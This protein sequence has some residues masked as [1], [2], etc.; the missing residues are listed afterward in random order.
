[1]EIE[2][3]KKLF[4]GYAELFDIHQ[5][6][7]GEYVF[8]VPK[9]RIDRKDFSVIGKLVKQEQGE[10]VKFDYATKEGGYFRFKKGEAMSTATSDKKAVLIK[11]IF[12]YADNI[13]IVAREVEKQASIIKEK[14]KELQEK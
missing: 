10:Y 1:V 12:A 7:G 9:K 13:E 6:E 2:D 14:L 3:V 11:D 5:K 4:G 8:A